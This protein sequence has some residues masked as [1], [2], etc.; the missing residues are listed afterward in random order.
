MQQLR[1]NSG[2]R[3]PKSRTTH[4]WLG[5]IQVVTPD[6]SGA[7]PIPLCGSAVARPRTGSE[8]SHLFG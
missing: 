5:A 7:L 2:K 3:V 6:N 4:S 8:I 1:Q